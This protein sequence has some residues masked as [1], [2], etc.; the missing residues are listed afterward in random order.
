MDN[1]D[2]PGRRREIGHR[3]LVGPPIGGESVSKTR[4]AGEL[5]HRVTTGLAPSDESI[6]NVTANL[7]GPTNPVPVEH[8]LQFIPMFESNTSM[9]TSGVKCTLGIAYS[10]TSHIRYAGDKFAYNSGAFFH[11][12]STSPTPSSA[13]SP[14]SPS[15]A[16]SFTAKLSGGTQYSLP[17]ARPFPY[18]QRFRTIFQ[19]HC[20]AMCRVDRSFTPPVRLGRPPYNPLRSPQL[21]GVF[22][23]VFLNHLDH[24]TKP[25]RPKS[26]HFI[27]HPLA[28]F[29]LCPLSPQPIR[30]P[31]LQTSTNAT[32]Q[33]IPVQSSTPHRP[34][35]CIS[36]P[37]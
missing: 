20:E 33:W 2:R 13:F 18:K 10:V 31:R 14:I 21:P 26:L 5:V 17:P 29:V 15:I 30:R 36:L 24:V 1:R 28:H 22:S 16:P 35:P 34:S 27:Q 12:I 25:H 8:L 9:R 32:T 23:A 6:S 19:L 11:Q 3:Y 7:V 4:K 37:S